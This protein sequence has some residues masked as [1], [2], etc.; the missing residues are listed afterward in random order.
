MVKKFNLCREHKIRI[1]PG[2]ESHDR[3]LAAPKRSEGGF[4]LAS[5]AKF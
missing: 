3:G 5:T 4:L 1:R 2:I